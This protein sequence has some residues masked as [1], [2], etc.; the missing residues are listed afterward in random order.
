ML[1]SKDM[2]GNWQ[3]VSSKELG[4]NKRLNLRT[5]KNVN[6]ALVTSASVCKTDG[7]WETHRMYEDFSR[8]YERTEPKRVTAKVVEQ[9]HLNHSL[10]QIALDAIEFYK[11]KE[12][13]DDQA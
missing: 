10:E 11:D 9:Q 8:V 6:G 4:D 12:K 1:I 5:A 2:R 7:I 3:A 13:Q